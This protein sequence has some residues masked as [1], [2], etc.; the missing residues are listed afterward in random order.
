MTGGEG[1]GDDDGHNDHSFEDYGIGLFVLA[2]SVGIGARSVGANAALMDKRRSARKL[3]KLVSRLPY[4]VLVML[5]GSV[6][7]RS[8]QL[9]PSGSQTLEFSKLTRAYHSLPATSVL[10]HYSLTPS[11]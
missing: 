3:L 2:L 9:L 4:T 6:R 10:A 5:L 11:T 1:G 7:P 8:T